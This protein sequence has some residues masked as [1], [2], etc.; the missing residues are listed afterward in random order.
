MTTIELLSLAGALIL[1]AGGVTAYA[2]NKFTT[3]EEVATTAAHIREVTEGRHE[4]LVEKLD[5]L[6]QCI[7]ELKDIINE[8]REWKK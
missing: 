6:H 2:Y 1:Q 3:K 5:H 7:H 8:Q 4:V